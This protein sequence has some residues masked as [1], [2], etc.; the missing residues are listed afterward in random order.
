[1]RWP[2]FAL[3]ALLALSAG[4]AWSQQQQRGQQAGLAG[5]PD[6]LRQALQ[7]SNTRRYSGVR[8]V[9]YMRGPD[10]KRH[11]EYILR[12]GNRSR[13]TFPPDSEFAGQIIVETVA[14][15][16]HYFPGRNEIHVMPPRRE[17]AQQRLAR[18]LAR[19]DRM[20]IRIA[21]SGGDQ[22]AG[23][24]TEV[25]TIS[26]RNGNVLQKL[27]IDRQ[28]ALILKRELFDPAGARIGFFEFNRVDFSPR[29]SDDM[30][31]IVRRGAKVIR[32]EDVARDLS[33][34]NDMLHVLIPPA[35]G[36]RLEHSRMIANGRILH[37]T[38][39]SRHGHMSLFQVK[40]THDFSNM[41]GRERDNRVYSWQMQGR[42]F[43]L[44]GNSSAEELRRVAR[45]LGDK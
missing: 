13:V 15:R 2:A 8:T 12:D 23:R 7:S 17:E 44:V 39:Q 31:R 21:S 26:D 1:M 20:G 41:A 37:Q 38:Y 9:E 22:V 16:Q 28:Q 32:P 10:R 43:A 30:F 35:E 6:L 18:L 11:V 25:I 24:P 3:S 29:V 42:T 40:G 4:A 5:L 33:Q 19:A 14:E 45:L 34:R 36:Y 27:W